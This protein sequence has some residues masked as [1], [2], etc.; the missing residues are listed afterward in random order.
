MINKPRKNNGSMMKKTLSRA[1]SPGEVGDAGR[2]QSNAKTKVGE[3][4]YFERDTRYQKRQLALR[5][6]SAQTDSRNPLQDLL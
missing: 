4:F 3:L 5:S 2:K 1:F 6:R